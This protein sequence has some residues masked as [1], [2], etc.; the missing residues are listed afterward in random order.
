M[1]VS[2]DIDHDKVL[3]LCHVVDLLVERFLVVE[4]PSSTTNL[5]SRSPSGLQRISRGVHLKFL[6]YL[7]FFI[8]IALT[9]GLLRANGTQA[10]NPLVKTRAD[11]AFLSQNYA[12]KRAE[13]ISNVA[14]ELSLTLTG[15]EDFSG[16]SKIS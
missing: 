2:H 11:N 1:R 14:Y 6:F 12:K 16:I 13:R 7:A 10:N 8:S 3:Q 5:V 4:W 15:K 9:S